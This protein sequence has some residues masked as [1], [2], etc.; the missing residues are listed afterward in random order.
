M[1]AKGDWR[2]SERLWFV[3]L[4]LFALFAWADDLSDVAALAPT[5]AL[6]FA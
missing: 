1:G 2:G 6:V 5:P 4:G 3:G